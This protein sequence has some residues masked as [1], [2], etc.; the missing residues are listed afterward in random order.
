MSTG[1]HGRCA[2]LNYNPDETKRNEIQ[3][4]MKSSRS[5][6]GSDEPADGSNDGSMIGSVDRFF[7]RQTT[8]ETT[9][10]RNNTT[11]HGTTRHEQ[12][13]K[14][15]SVVRLSVRLSFFIVFLLLCASKVLRSK[16]QRDKAVALGLGRYCSPF[17]VSI[18]LADKKLGPNDRRK[19][20]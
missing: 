19:K 14:L 18:P 5:V 4:Q 16:R 3:I 6:G 20:R 2:K 10:K 13:K 1:H 11:Q 9:Q 17:G 12:T 8:N 7:P 15:V